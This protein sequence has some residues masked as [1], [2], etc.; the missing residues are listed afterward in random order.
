MNKP[1]KGPR[2]VYFVCIAIDQSGLDFISK[3]IEASSP[4]EAASIFYDL[5]KLKAKTIH[6]PYRLK[7]AQ[8]IE[9]T[10]HLRFAANQCKAIYKDWEVNA[11]YLKEPADH[12]YLLFIKRLDG[13]KTP[14]PGTTVV[15]IAELRP[16]NEKNISE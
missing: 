15:P 1:K 11:L 14:I 5:T 16:Y 7:K 13:K 10:R 8:I 3:Q 12:A 2:P 6:G 9:N 4:T